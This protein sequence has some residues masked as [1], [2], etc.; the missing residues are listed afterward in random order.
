[1][2]ATE[3]SSPATIMPQVYDA[4]KVDSV[5]LSVPVGEMKVVNDSR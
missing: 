5:G 1:M 3:T 4:A 2:V